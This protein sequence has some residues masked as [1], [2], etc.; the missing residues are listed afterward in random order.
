MRIIDEK[1]RIFS[2]INLIDFFVILFLL[3]LTPVFYFGYKIVTKKPIVETPEREFIDIEINCRLIK[4]RPELL[5]N[6]SVGDKELDENGQVIGE[7]I[8]LGQDEPYKY[9]FDIGE[10]QKITK[11]DP[12]LKQ[13]DAKIKL[14]AEVK[15]DKPYYKDKMIKID[16]PLEFGTDDFTLIAIPFEEK[17]EEERIINLYVT[18]INLDEKLLEEISVG[19]R[20]MD[21]NGN[22]IAEIL[23][24]DKEETSFLGFD[25][26]GGSFVKEEAGTKKQISARMRLKCQVKDGSQLYFKGEKVEYNSTLEFKTD[27]YTITGLVAFKEKWG[28]LR[29][30]FSKVVPEVAR[31]IRKGDIEKDAFERTIAR[32]GSIISNEPALVETVTAEGKFITLNH[33]FNRD[34]VVSLDV[35]CTEKEGAYYFKDYLAKMGN[36]IAFN[37]DSYSILGMI[38]GVEM[39]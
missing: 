3:F 1:G 12:I 14:K 4:L 39:K 22:T 24:L 32:I 16:S 27:K 26:G 37:T 2:K 13:I 25:L 36:E 17:G 21:E 30:K 8:S 10:K 7:I 5:K 19:D 34:V 31:N 28:T 11:E 18:L 33:P 38:V 35:L 6:I 20:E 9:E 15:E 29:V 23:S